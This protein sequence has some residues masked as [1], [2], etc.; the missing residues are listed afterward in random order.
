MG[1]KEAYEILSQLDS[2]HV[3][4]KEWDAIFL[5]GEY[6][7]LNRFRRTYEFSSMEEVVKFL[8]GS[9]LVKGVVVQ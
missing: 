5:L 3:S 8:N 4:S 7:K 2:S 9:G 1:L 6:V